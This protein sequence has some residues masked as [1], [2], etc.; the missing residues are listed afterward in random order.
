M[1]WFLN[2]EQ[3]LS[4][5]SKILH[6]EP[7]VR[8]SEAGALFCPVNR[9]GR[10]QMRKMTDQAVLGILKKRRAAAHVQ[11]FSPHDLRRTFISDLLDA[12]ADISLL[13]RSWPVTPVCRRPAAMT[14]QEK[15]PNV[16]RPAFY[17]YLIPVSETII[18]LPYYNRKLR[19]CILFKI[20]KSGISLSVLVRTSMP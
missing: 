2:F 11:F 17:T 6:L 18:Y 8:G 4:R 9:G 20:N 15:W 13:S 12:G 14:G 10:L 1:A 3:L 7:S 19:H 5:T 16:K